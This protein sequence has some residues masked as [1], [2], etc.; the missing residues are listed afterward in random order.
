MVECGIPK[1]WNVCQPYIINITVFYTLYLSALDS[2]GNIL[3]FLISPKSGLF[4]LNWSSISY[5]ILNF[6]LKS[7]R[8]TEL[9][10]L[11]VSD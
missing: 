1:L 7:S 9:K 8:I 2:L 4:F 6:L 5:I 11:V 10:P 3:V